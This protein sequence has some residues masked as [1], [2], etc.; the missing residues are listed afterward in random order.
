MFLNQRMERLAE[1]P[2][3]F[4]RRTLG[5]ARLEFSQGFLP[6]PDTVGQ[7]L[8]VL[9]LLDLLIPAELGLLLS[10]EFLLQLLVGIREHEEGHPETRHHP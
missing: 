4:P 8:Q 2:L 5:Q 10:L 1:I 3:E 7:L 9:K 6:A